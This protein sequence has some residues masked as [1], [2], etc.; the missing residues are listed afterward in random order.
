MNPQQPL[1]PNYLDQIAPQTAKRSFSLSRP[2]LILL[3]GIVAI[4]LVMIMAYVAGAIGNAKKEPWERLSARIA[5]TAEIAESSEG[6]IKNSQLRS[7]NSNVKISLTN[8]QRDLTA[9]LTTVGINVEKISPSVI[10]SESSDKMIARL[11]DARLNAKYDSTYAREMSYQLSNLL[12][13]L[14]QMY[15]SSSNEMNKTF[16]ETTYNNFLPV[17]KSLSEFSASNE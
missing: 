8:T 13:L 5:A 2:R 11:E 16:L 9:P 14:R 7:V 6:K 3:I 12:T 10:S 17:Q 1:P 4:I 15:S